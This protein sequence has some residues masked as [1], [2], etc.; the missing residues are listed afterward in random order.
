MH[1]QYPWVLWFLLALAIPILVHLFNF[2]RPRR[3]LFSNLLFL[4][5]VTEVVQRR[6]KLKQYL[7]LATRLLLFA[8]LICLFAG[9]Y[10][11]RET[12]T[13]AKGGGTPSVV[14]II[15]NSRSMSVQDERGNYLE[16]ARKLAYTLIQ[17]HG[18]SAEFQVHTTGNLPLGA[19]FAP[20]GQAFLQLDRLDY[21]DR[22][23]GY[24][25]IL[26]NRRLYFSEAANPLHRLYFISDFQQQTVLA[27][28]VS[29]SALEADAV[30]V[31]FV[32]VG[33]RPQPNL[34]ITELAFEGALLEKD[35]P[36]TLNLRVQ[37]DGTEPAN[38]LTLRL[39]VEGKATGVSQVDVPA[40][41]SRE[42]QMVFTPSQRGWQSAFVELQ[43]PAVEFDNRRHF[44][45]YIPDNS[46]ILLVTGE[47]DPRYLRLFFGQLTR[48]YKLEE[49]DARNF[50]GKRLEDY[51]MIIMA[52][53]PEVSA[54][55]ATRLETWTRQGGGLLVLPSEKMDIASLNT[56]LGRM[57]GGNFGK[58][59]TYG[60]PTPLAMPDLQDVLFEG[61]FAKARAQDKFDSPAISR[62]FT[63]APTQ[64]AVH[65]VPLKDQSGKPFLVRVPV[66]DGML[67]VFTSY[68]SLT[69]SDFPLK[70]SFVP[71]LYRTALLLNHMARQELYQTLGKF[72]LRKLK[73]RDN[74]SIRLVSQQDRN[75]SMVP[76][77]YVQAGQTFLNFERT[78]VTAGSWHIQSGD[79][80]LEKIS[81]NLPAA[82]SDLRTL[83][84]DKLRAYL[85]EAGAGFVTLLDAHEAVLRKQ[86][87]EQAGGMP[88]W[89]YFLLGVLLLLLAEALIIRFV[90]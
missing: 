33:G 21:A 44:S 8:L 59:H 31:A 13:A 51:A 19:P 12:G 18:S 7:L 45:F 1:F 47:E 77:Q 48:Q 63:Y 58:L 37:N 5:Q 35:K 34:Y 25:E 55:L 79:T 36:A 73:A 16:Q 39:V 70:T 14:I 29:A 72:Q 4:R 66:D 86:V 71:V 81:F 69:W 43:D 46:R 27:D 24:A 22:A 23:V 74:T 57:G 9:P 52:G 88:L 90:K 15:D 41:E 32:P 62:I 68:P 2:R 65:F 54:G 80:T 85:D 6:L 30:Q 49:T 17:S 3:L 67:C 56:L 83:P 11:P 50:P 53:V 28:T 76:D 20:Q 42:V 82:E 38:G 26:A 78:G 10:I 89:R 87:E 75:L 61:V 60:T 84:A 64:S 40:G